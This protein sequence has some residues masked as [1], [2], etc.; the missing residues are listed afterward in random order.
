MEVYPAMVT[1]AVHQF[2]GFS[3]NALQIRSSG[4]KYPFIPFA[5]GP[6]SHPSVVIQIKMRRLIF[7]DG[8][9]RREY[10]L[11]GSGSSIYSKK[12]QLGRG[13]VKGTIHHNGVA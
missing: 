8:I 9:I 7:R 1:E 3:I 13:T 2:S 4:I 5:I 10:P 11:S 12:L 6:I